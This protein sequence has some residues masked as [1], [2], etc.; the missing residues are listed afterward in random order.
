MKN[1]SFPTKLLWIDL[2]MTGLDA[3]AQRIIEVAALVTD[4]ELNELA[5]L[6]RIIHQSDAVLENAEAWPK[7]NMAELFDQV[8]ASTHAEADV[9]A[10]LCQLVETHFGS[11]KAILAGNSIHQDRK[12]IKQWWTDLEKLLHYRMLDVST[13]K[14]WLQGSKQAVFEKS[15]T[16]R[17]MDDILESIAEFKWALEAL[18]HDS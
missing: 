6:E 17:A 1:P 12:F 18:K 7:E 2:E 11:E 9:Q 5:R 15:E 16:H 8:R 4:F 3:Q 14:V 10:E 13:L